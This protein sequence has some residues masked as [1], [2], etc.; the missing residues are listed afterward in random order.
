[1]KLELTGVTSLYLIGVG[2][3]KVNGAASSSSGQGLALGTRAV[4]RGD[5]ASMHPAAVMSMTRSPCESLD[6]GNLDRVC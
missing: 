6:S 3:P 5:V 1:M 4:I 2:L